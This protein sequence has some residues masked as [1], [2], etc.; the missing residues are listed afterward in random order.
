MYD[1]KSLQI[2]FLASILLHFAVFLSAP[3]VGALPKRQ[4]ISPIKVSYFK[5]KERPEKLVGQK[6]KSQIFPTVAPEALPEVKK[7]DIINQP[8]QPKPAAK[9]EQVKKE[10]P[11]VETIGDRGGAVIDGK[12]K[13]FEA[14]VDEEK[15]NSRKATYIGYYRSV[16]EKI[17]YY[18]DRNYLK[19][20][21]AAQGEVFISFTVASS[22]ELLHIM[23]IDKRSAE[24]PLLRDI[25]INSIRDAAPFP[26]FPQ[27][28][29]QYQITFNVVISFELNK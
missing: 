7:E 3:Y 24:D 26:G 28:M 13:K 25:A 15:D 16:R 9:Q 10:E 22:G 8:L 29:N 14:V 19:E 18:A 17:R 2:A 1:N 5:V 12:G 6:P 20:G 27:G 4:P 23:V 11:R 21:S